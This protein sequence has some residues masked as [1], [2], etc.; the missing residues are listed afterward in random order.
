MYL[1]ELR[2]SNPPQST[3]RALNYIEHLASEMKVPISAWNINKIFGEE[4]PSST[5]DLTSKFIRYT[6][7]LE[8]Q[9]NTQLDADTISYLEESALRL[10]P[11]KRTE[12]ERRKQTCVQR[13]RNYYRSAESEAKVLQET[14]LQ[15]RSLEGAGNFVQIVQEVLRP[16]YWEFFVPSNSL[17]VAG[18][19]SKPVKIARIPDD[20][21]RDY[22]LDFGR[23]KFGITKEGWIQ[24]LQAHEQDQA[25]VFFRDSLAGRLQAPGPYHLFFHTIDSGGNICWGTGADAA[26]ECMAKMQYADAFL[27]LQRVLADPDGYLPYASIPQFFTLGVDRNFE[28]PWLKDLSPEM[29]AAYGVT[30]ADFKLVLPEKNKAPEKPLTY[31][32]SRGVY[33]HCGHEVEMSDD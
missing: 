22:A 13:M 20:K 18:F 27:I 24:A 29:R 4:L 7:T 33:F 30:E 11:A 2:A 17:F 31:A 10:M 9:K 6:R 25:G 28:R 19:I 14:E 8:V 23:L 15:L 3:V 21:G 16:G 32:G 5:K 12:L 1:H 26:N